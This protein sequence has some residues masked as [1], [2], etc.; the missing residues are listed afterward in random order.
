MRRF[1]N[2]FSKLLLVAVFAGCMFAGQAYSQEKTFH[3]AHVFAPQENPYH[4]FVYKFKEVVESRSKGNIKIIEH[5]AMELGSEREYI[6]SCQMGTLD[7]AIVNASIMTTFTPSLDWTALYFVITNGDQ[8]AKVLKN[9]KVLQKLE[10]LLDINLMPLSYVSAGPRGT[11]TTTKPIEKMSDLKG[12]KVRVMETPIHVTAWD[13]M[14]ANPTPL[15]YGELYT[16]LEYGTV[17]GAENPISGYKGVKF[18]EPAPYFAF[19]NHQWNVAVAFMSKEVWN[20][21]STEEQGI[22]KEA[23]RLGLEYNLEKQVS[24]EKQQVKQLE[25]MGVRFTYPDIREFKEKVVPALKK[26]EEKVGEEFVEM[27]RN[28]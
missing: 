15:A 19:T 14:G 10:S 17:D 20:K 12:L 11:F 22:F 26:Y 5:A 9:E 16:A 28:M 27:M 1:L 23:A 13:S 8:A 2:V 21:L 6:E 4:N 3:F 18:Y 7:I 25:E 24:E